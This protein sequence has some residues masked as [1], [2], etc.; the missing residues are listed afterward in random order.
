MA[1]AALALIDFLPRT[2]RRRG[3]GEA[4]QPCRFVRINLHH[5]CLGID[6][7]ASPFSTSSRARHVDSQSI[8][9]RRDE[10][11][12]CDEGFELL[13]SPCMH[14]RSSIGQNIFSQAF[15]GRKAAEQLEGVALRTRPLRGHCWWDIAGSRWEK[16][17]C[18]SSD[19]RRRHD[20]I[21]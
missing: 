6:R 16:V 18:R 10:L 21:L 7:R 17:T 14:L 9:G 4:N 12:P 5:S 8:H 20:R 3:H 15:G 2:S 1:Y 19:Q 11:V 13:D